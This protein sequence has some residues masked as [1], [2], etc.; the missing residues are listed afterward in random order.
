MSGQTSDNQLQSYD[1]EASN[2]ATAARVNKAVQ[3]VINKER[4]LG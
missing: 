1:C 2:E 4:D 3:E